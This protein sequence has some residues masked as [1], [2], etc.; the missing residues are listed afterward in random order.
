MGYDTRDLTG[1]DVNNNRMKTSLVEIKTGTYVEEYE[2]KKT[3]SIEI[4][5]LS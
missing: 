5:A 4:I 3:T 1:R 2:K